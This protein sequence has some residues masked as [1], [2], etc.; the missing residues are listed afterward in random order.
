M[1]ELRH[2][3]RCP[4]HGPE[5]LVVRNDGSFTAYPDNDNQSGRFVAGDGEL[6][7]L[8][9]GNIVNVTSSG[10]VPLLSNKDL[11]SALHTQPLADIGGLAVRSDGDIYFVAS[12]INQSGCQNRIVER[13]TG[14]L[15]SQIWSS[16]PSRTGVCF[17]SIRRDRG[18]HLGGLTDG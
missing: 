10:L 11:L 8:F 13:I 18:I 16:S 12:I 17:Y 6:V 9:N 1:H 3:V 14:G 7:G 4:G 2:H 15:I 5:L